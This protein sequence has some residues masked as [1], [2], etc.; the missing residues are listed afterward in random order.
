MGLAGDHG[1]RYELQPRAGIAVIALP[2]QYYGTGNP[3]N[4]HGLHYDSCG[5]A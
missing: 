4:R 1:G 2:I 5:P 3:R